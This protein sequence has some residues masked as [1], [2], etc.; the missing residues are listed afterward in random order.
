MYEVFFLNNIV[1][2]TLQLAGKPMLYH[3]E[4]AMGKNFIKTL[5]NR[6]KTKLMN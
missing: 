3:A 5:G 1:V 6:I 4:K 2:D